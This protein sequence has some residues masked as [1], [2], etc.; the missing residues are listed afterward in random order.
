M[1]GE[2]KRKND[3]IAS[4]MKKNVE[5]ILKSS[6]DPL[7]VRHSTLEVFNNLNLIEI[8]FEKIKA[9]SRI[10]KNKLDRREV[11]TQDQFGTEDPTPQLIFILDAVNFCFWANRDQ[12]KWTVEYPRGNFISNGWYAFVTSFERARKEDIPILSAKYLRRLTLSD[13]KHIFRSSNSTEIPLLSERVKILNEVGERLENKFEGRIENLLD[14]TKG[15]SQEIVKDIVEFFPTF[16][17]FRTHNGK[18]IKFYKRAQIFAY[19][20]SFL[21]ELN[22]TDLSSLT[23]FADYKIPQILRALEITKYKKPLAQMVDNYI[24]LKEGSV[25]EIEIRA[26][27]IWVCEL[28]AHQADI[29]PCMVDNVLWKMSQGLKDVKP[30]HRV[31]TT[32][33]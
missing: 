5:K 18:R 26:S 8:D 20:L 22:I 23:A 21:S 32:S 12:E 3:K 29:M 16:E 27:T 1:N 33:Y 13:A 10:V 17:D 30:Y 28:I 19:D 6:P 11:L 25:G 7:N 24:V 9:I 14:S 2:F 4:N 15:D 31:L